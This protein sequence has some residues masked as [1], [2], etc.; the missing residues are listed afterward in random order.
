MAR[1]AVL[2][3]I[4]VVLVAF[5][6]V[7]VYGVVSLMSFFQ[8]PGPDDDPGARAALIHYLDAIEH[9]DYA[10]AY[11]QLCADSLGSG[12][13]SEQDHVDFLRGQPAIVSYRVGG[14]TRVTG[15]DGTSTRFP[16]HL[17]YVD[18]TGADLT[19]EVDVQTNGP[20]VCDGPGYRH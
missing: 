17:S 4:A 16:V 11:A 12:R 13:Y 15:V 3:V 5:A 10:G 8:P 19:F 9:G 18:G 2:A 7:T 6:A 1:R 14:G 20:R